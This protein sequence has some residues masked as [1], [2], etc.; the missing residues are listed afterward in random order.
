VNIPKELLRKREEKKNREVCKP[1]IPADGSFCTQELD[2]QGDQWDTGEAMPKQTSKKPHQEGYFQ[3]SIIWKVAMGKI[4]TR[5]LT[6][7][8][9]EKGWVSFGVS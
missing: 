4:H 2:A 1:V 5:N 7:G 3:P 8:F 9:A 6:K